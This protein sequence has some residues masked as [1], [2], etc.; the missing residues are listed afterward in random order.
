MALQIPA[1]APAYRILVDGRV[2]AETGV[3]AFEPAAVQA[4]YLPKTVSFV[5]PGKTFD[6]MLQ[7]A[8]DLYPHG[9]IWYSMTL[10]TERSMLALKEQTGI[11]E[12]SV[13]GGCALLG[14]YM[15]PMMRYA[16]VNL[17]ASSSDSINTSRMK[18]YGTSCRSIQI[19]QP[20]LY[21]IS[22]KAA[23]TKASHP[24]S[25]SS[26]PSLFRQH[27]HAKPNKIYARLNKLMKKRFGSSGENAL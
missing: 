18:P 7:V 10:G 26:A 24:V 27:A 23:A 15:R 19:L 16:F 13:F 4:A 21:K 11:V 3:V 9:G 14:L 6:L 12:I 22:C 8:N 1:I 20:A 25:W 2:I 5:P 17:R